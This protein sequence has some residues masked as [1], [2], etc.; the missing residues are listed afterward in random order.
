MSPISTVQPVVHSTP[1]STQFGLLPGLLQAAPVL[2]C[3]SR[4]TR[5]PRVCG[6]FVGCLLT[7][8]VIFGQLLADPR[9][10]SFGSE[11]I[12]IDQPQRPELGLPDELVPSASP[13]PAA[14]R[15]ISMLAQDLGGKNK[16]L[17]HAEQPSPSVWIG[18]EC[19]IEFRKRR[20]RIRDESE[21]SK[22]EEHRG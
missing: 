15:C 9:I 17:P 22:V 1:Q 8:G 5:F 10:L 20:K 12:Q 6:I 3:N 2:G 14:L 4:L 21:P 18:L 16:D 13:K 7:F 19:G 11:D